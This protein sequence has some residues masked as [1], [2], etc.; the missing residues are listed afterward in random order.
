MR[1]RYTKRLRSKKQRNTR[2]RMRSRRRYQR[3]GWGG[4]KM[5]KSENVQNKTMMYGGWGPVVN[6]I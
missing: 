6:G 4:L 5:Y 1:A 3:G 2:R